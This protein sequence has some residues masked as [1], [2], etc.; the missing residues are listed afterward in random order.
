MSGLLGGKRCQAFAGL[1]EVTAGVSAEVGEAGGER[2]AEDGEDGVGEGDV[3]EVEVGGLL[4]ELG[5]LLL[6]IQ[7]AG[8][9][10]GKGGGGSGLEAGGGFPFS[11]RFDGGFKLAEEPAAEG[12]GG[13]RASA[14]AIF[15]AGAGSG[16]THGVEVGEVGDGE[17][18]EAFGD[19][20]GR[21]AGAGGGL[22]FG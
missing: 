4:K 22:G 9:G 6:R 5:D 13:S 19:A 16:G 21:G 17:M 11:A 18:V 12:A 3:G 10:L 14:Q 1:P 8:C 20:P 2:K 15:G 7:E